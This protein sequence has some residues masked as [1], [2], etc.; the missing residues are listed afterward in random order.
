MAVILP[1]AWP[2]PPPKEGSSMFS[3]KKQKATLAHLNAREE[4]H[5]PDESVLAVDL[6]FKANVSNDF[7]SE[8]SPTL[9][10]SL[11]DKAAVDDLAQEAGHMPVLR[12]SS[13][14]AI[15]W[16]GEMPNA[17]VVLHGA[18]KAKDLEFVAKVNK[19]YRHEKRFA[20][21]NHCGVAR[22]VR[23]DAVEW[24]HYHQPGVRCVL[25]G[26]GRAQSGAGGYLQSGGPAGVLG[27]QRQQQERM[28]GRDGWE[29]VRGV[30]RSQSD[31]FGR[32][33]I[34]NRWQRLCHRCHHFLAG[35]SGG[36][37][38]GALAALVM[39]APCVCRRWL[40]PALCSPRPRPARALRCRPWRAVPCESWRTAC[41]CQCLRSR[42]T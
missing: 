29:R 40:E 41:E 26:L 36:F 14:E 31:L 32:R 25:R 30:R 28:A 2:F 33:P 17:V 9:K 34:T 39:L 5:G 13:L 37:S 27:G 21:C 10:W 6:S 19:R 8:L 12:Y 42:R 15:S 4:N 11:Y 24:N 35:C 16:K 38:A 23:A 3:F 7:L 20:V 18:T 22:G 1:D